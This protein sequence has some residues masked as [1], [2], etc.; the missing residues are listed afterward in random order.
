M[1]II[2]YLHFKAKNKKHL[3]TAYSISPLDFSCDNTIN[4]TV[5]LCSAMLNH[6]KGIEKK[7]TSIT[8]WESGTSLLKQ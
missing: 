1:L 7:C 2:T 8:I 6:L 3:F 4:F 5:S